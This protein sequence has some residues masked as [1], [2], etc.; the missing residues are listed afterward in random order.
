MNGHSGSLFFP[1]I[2][3][4]A[5]VLFRLDNDTEA[6]PEDVGFQQIFSPGVLYVHGL[7]NVP[8][9]FMAGVQLSP[10]LRKFGDESLNTLRFNLSAV[11]DLPL[12][13]FYTRNRAKLPKD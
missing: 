3:L 1:L 4:G 7:P 5:L 12:A 6:L 13:N 10:Q 8:I 11:V 9:S 2:D